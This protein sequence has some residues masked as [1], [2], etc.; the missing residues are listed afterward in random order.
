MGKV[1]LN[2]ITSNYL[3]LSSDERVIYFC[4][5]FSW[6]TQ[7]DYRHLKLHEYK[8]FIRSIELVSVLPG[9]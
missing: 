5:Y 4:I 2:L 3:L 6:S 7:A 1:I 8:L 9:V